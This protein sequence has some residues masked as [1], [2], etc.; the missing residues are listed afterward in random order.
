MQ[1]YPRVTAVQ[2]NNVFIFDGPDGVK[3]ITASNLG[4]NNIPFQILTTAWQP[5]TT[6]PG[7]NFQFT[8]AVEGVTS[9][10]L[11]MASYDLGTLIAAVDAGLAPAGDTTNG[12]VIFYSQEIPPNNLAGMYTIF[13]GVV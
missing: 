11:V 5:S 7:F 9:A 10:D 8:L 3:S 4:F 6:Y 2:P 1:D 12:A 13:K